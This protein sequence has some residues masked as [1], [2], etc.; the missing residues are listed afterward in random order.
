MSEDYDIIY[1]ARCPK[2]GHST[3]HSRSCTNWCEEGYFDE[4]DDD[5][6]DFA[7]GELYTQCKECK[8]TGVEV[9]CPKCGENLSGLSV[10]FENCNEQMEEME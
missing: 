1:D 5:P 2:C 3:V 9:W 6:I 7:P 4:N 8:G 10:V